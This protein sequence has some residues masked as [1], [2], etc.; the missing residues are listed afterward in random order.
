MQMNRCASVLFLAKMLVI[1]VGNGLSKY[2]HLP[3]KKDCFHGK[4]GDQG[5][6]HKTARDLFHENIRFS[7]E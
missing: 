4:V 1:M 7:E 2:S 6:E 3:H 5:F